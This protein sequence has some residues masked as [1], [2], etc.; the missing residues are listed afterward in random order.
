M[1]PVL[2]KPHRNKLHD[3]YHIGCVAFSFVSTPSD[4]KRQCTRL[5]T[6]RDHLHEAVRTH[7]HQD[8]NLNYHYSAYHDPPIDMKKVRLLIAN[9]ACAKTQVFKERLFNAKKIINFYEEVAGWKSRSKI[10]TAKM[11]VSSREAYLLTGP[12]EWM[13]Y[14]NLLSMITLIVRV[15]TSYGP[16]NFKDNKSLEEEYKGILEDFGNIE[17]NSVKE[18]NYG[19][20]YSTDV[21]MDL[22]YLKICH[23]KLYV[24]MKNYKRL[25]TEGIKKAYPSMG[26]PE[27]ID[28]HPH[29]GI[30]ALCSFTSASKKLC[31]EFKK[32]FVKSE[33]EERNEQKEFYDRH[34]S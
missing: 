30:T 26:N 17:L 2:I 6:C 9:G 24:I 10:L 1:K 13:S 18:H 5:L 20:I 25:F 22:R 15:I 27:G 7:V 31:K 8:D 23:R 12:G 21:D 19:S 34:G 29:G 16:I 4:G 33:E 28:F 11:G 14:P 32:V 3:T